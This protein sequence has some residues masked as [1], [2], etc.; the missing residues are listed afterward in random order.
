M[1]HHSAQQYREQFTLELAHLIGCQPESLPA[2]VTKDVA[3]TF[4]GLANKKTLNVW[5]STGRHGIVMVKIGRITQ[6]TTE[7]LINLKVAGLSMAGEVA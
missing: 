2:S 4:I 1:Q 7:W 5:H 3:A 6:P